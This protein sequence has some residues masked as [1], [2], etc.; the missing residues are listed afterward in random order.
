MDL[1]EGSTGG[2]N[3]EVLPLQVAKPLLASVAALCCH[4]RAPQPDP[5]IW[6]PGWVG[7]RLSDTHRLSVPCTGAWSRGEG[8]GCVQACAHVHTPPIFIQT[9]LT[10]QP[11]AD[12]VRGCGKVGSPSGVL[13]SVGTLFLQAPFHPLRHRLHLASFPPWRHPGATLKPTEEWPPIPA[14]LRRFAGSRR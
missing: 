12:G 9:P 13:T 1:L 6:G 5:S 14:G 8:H 11:H 3:Q 10:S 4:Q 7:L 2:G